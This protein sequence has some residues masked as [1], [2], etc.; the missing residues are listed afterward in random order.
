M[1]EYSSNFWRR[2]TATL[3]G[4]SGTG[5]VVVG[6]LKHASAPSRTE[7]VPS[8]MYDASLLPFL[9]HCSDPASHSTISDWTLHS[10]RTRSMDPTTSGPIPSPI[11]TAAVLPKTA[12]F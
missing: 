8:G 6:P 4:A 2:V 10:L 3:L 11:M 9:S 7:M 1:L 5:I 12:G